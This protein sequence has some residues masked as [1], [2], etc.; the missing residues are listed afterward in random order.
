MQQQFAANSM[1]QMQQQ[2]AFPL[3]PQINVAAAAAGG[4]PEKV[5]KAD[6]NV[7]LLSLGTVEKEPTIM[8]ADPQH[9]AQCQATLSHVSVLQNV[10]GEADT[11]TWIW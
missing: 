8:T 9:C 1:P 7:V 6:A 10:E 4:P 11:K 2:A 3:P 5:A